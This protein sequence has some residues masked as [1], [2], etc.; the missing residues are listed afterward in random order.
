M[1]TP[2]A[3]NL[4]T[5]AEPPR[6]CFPVDEYCNCTWEVRYNCDGEPPAWGFPY[7]MGCVTENTP[8]SY[9]WSLVTDQDC[10]AQ[11]GT[12]TEG[13]CD[14]VTPTPPAGPG[15]EF[16]P[17]PDCCRLWCAANWQAICDPTGWT[18]GVTDS[19]ICL[20]NCTDVPW[21]PVTDY[22][23]TGFFCTQSF[24]NCDTESQSCD[25]YTPIEPDTP[26]CDIPTEPQWCNCGYSAEY[27]CTLGI[28]V[29]VGRDPAPCEL[30]NV[31][32]QTPWTI[33]PDDDCF[34]IR[35]AS[36]SWNGTCVCGGLDLDPCVIDPGDPTPLAPGPTCC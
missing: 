22:F 8:V 4:P 17:G 19:P 29:N 32:Q 24:T 5:L 14:S 1:P 36:V 18:I 31:D 23:Q 12:F 6:C 15:A 27:N 7:E 10:F 9:D 35:R 21:A 13:N 25:P 16:Q 33:S 11:S 3:P 26:P 28:W 30:A 34:A 2:P 20:S